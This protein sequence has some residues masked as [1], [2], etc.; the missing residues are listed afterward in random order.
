MIVNK[1]WSLSQT[2]PYSIF[3]RLFICFYLAFSPMLLTSTE[4]LLLQHSIPALASYTS[5]EATVF[6]QR[7]YVS[8]D[9][10]GLSAQGNLV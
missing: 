1:G 8:P 10:S 2:A 9:L 3:E 7:G 4:H 5:Q 6:I